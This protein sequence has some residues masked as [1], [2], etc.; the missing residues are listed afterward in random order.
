MFTLEALNAKYGDA[1]LLRYGKTRQPG[2]ILIDAGPAGVY[3]KVVRKRLDEL[4]KTD[5]AALPLRLVMVSHVDADHVTGVVELFTELKQLSDDQD[6]LLYDIA[7]LWHN[8]FKDGLKLVGASLAT[9]VKSSVTP[10]GLEA[11]RVPATIPISRDTRVALASVAQGGALRDL[12]K[13]LAVAVNDGFSPLVIAEGGTYPRVSMGDGLTFRVLGPSAM[14][15]DGLKKEWARKTRTKKASPAELADYVD[16]S[17]YNLSSIVVL[18]E[19]EGKTMLLTGDARGDDIVAA[20]EGA[21]LLK[22]SVALHVDLLKVP[23]HGSW[24]NLSKDFFERIEADHYVF[25]ADGKYGNPDPPSLRALIAARG[26]D[27]YTI[28]LTNSVAPAMKAIRAAKKKG[29]RFAVK[30]RAAKDLGLVIAL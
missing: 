26:N 22:S 5:T 2:L 9:N 3:Q 24:R 21:R 23:H 16:A 29:M 30:T 1:L 12:A 25:S 10:A 11:G 20:L 8:S 7:E 15:L 18:A 4:R 19:C 13:S 14:R 28:W 6:P 17:V 27:A